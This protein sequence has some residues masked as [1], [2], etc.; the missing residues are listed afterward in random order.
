[1]SLNEYHLG[2]ILIAII[3]IVIYL[4]FFF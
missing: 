4:K 1:L 3:L 2:V